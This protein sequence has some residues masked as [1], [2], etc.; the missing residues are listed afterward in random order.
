MVIRTVQDQDWIAAIVFLFKHWYF[1]W[2]D[3][4]L[5]LKG[6]PQ[7]YLPRSSF[8]TW[9]VLQVGVFFSS[10]V[11]RVLVFSSWKF[12]S[13][14][15]IE[16]FWTLQKKT[17]KFYFDTCS[18]PVEVLFGDQVRH[19]QQIFFAIWCKSFR[20]FCKIL[21]LFIKLDHRIWREKK[22][23]HQAS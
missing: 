9:L 21:P 8:D 11:F 1:H 14:F 13:A 5:T 17:Q 19:I 3:A 12:F 6:K 15:F 20:N 2:D 18:V 23:L 4:M 16:H 10:K 7:Q 22:G